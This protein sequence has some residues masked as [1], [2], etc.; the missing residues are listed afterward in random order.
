LYTTLKTEILGEEHIQPFWDKQEAV[1]V[2]CW[3]DQ[4]LMQVKAYHGPGSRILISPSKDGELIA[5]TMEKFGQGA[6]RGSSSR[7]GRGAFREL[8]RLAE[9]S[10]D[11]GITPDGPKGPRHKAKIGV[12][13]LGQVTGRPIVPFAFVC[14]SGHRF[15][16][17]DK[18]L[19]PYPWGRA[20]FMYGEPLR[21]TQDESAET[22]RARVEAALNANTTA[23]QEHLKKYDY[24]A[25]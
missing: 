13:K 11:M 9:M 14:S 1:I 18:F 7:G 3:H 10:Y 22:F 21:S 2:A 5:R 8:V 4:L 12:A 23:A 6:V 15:N 24:T 17:W 25:V 20:V 16:S 19:V